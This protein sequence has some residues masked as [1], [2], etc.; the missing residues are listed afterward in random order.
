MFQSRFR[1]KYKITDSIFT[2]G[3]KGNPY[4]KGD[5]QESTFIYKITMY[6][7]VSIP[8]NIIQPIS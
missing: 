8:Y 1:S 3:H 6:E 7:L 4:S 2:N 5:S